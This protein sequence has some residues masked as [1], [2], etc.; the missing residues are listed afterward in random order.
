MI[1]SAK[2]LLVG[3]VTVGM[4]SVG[5]LS[6]GTAGAAAATTTPAVVRNFDC[7]RATKVLTRIDK[8]EARI[9]AGL[10][11]LTA[12]EARLTKAGHTELA[13]RLQKRITR[14]ESTQFKA[15]LT[16]ASSA[17][18][19]KCH[20]SDPGSTPSAGAGSPA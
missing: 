14:L 16:R 9:A 20:V 6:L 4:L 18:E 19:A 5:G 8:G 11:K 1:P 2:K 12:A 10:P 17:I 15:R 13:N 3:S 7:A